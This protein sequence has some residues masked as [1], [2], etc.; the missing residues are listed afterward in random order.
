MTS[1]AER[2]A[3]AKLRE[4]DRTTEL[5][6]FTAGLDFQLD[7]FQVRACRALEAGDT[8][9]VAAPTGSGKTVVGEFAIHLAVTAGS[10]AFYTTPI[11][12]LSN[13]K[14]GDL[15]ATY[16]EAGVGL[17]TGDNSINGDAPVVVMTT[18]VLR[19]MLY[20]QSSALTGLSHVVMDEVHYLADRSRGAVWEEVLI[21]LPESV[22]VA[23]LSATVSNAEEFGDWL[24]TVRG[25]ATVIVE[26]HRPVP[27]WQHVAV[28]NRLHDLYADQDAGQLNPELARLAR[29]ARQAE[30]LNA[31]RGSYRRRGP[32]GP[33]PPSRIEVI[34]KL[35]Q[36]D[37]LPAITFIF[38]R[39][40]CDA[41]ADQCVAGGLRL[42]SAAEAALIRDIADTA[43]AH[44]PEA[45]L[46]LLGYDDWVDML[47]RGVAAHHAGMLPTFKEV[48]EGLF[49]QGLIKAVFATE[50]LALGINM[51]AR[52]VVLEKLSKWN[53]ETHADIT[54][55]EYTQL[56]GRAGRRGIDVEGHAVVVWHQ[57]LDPVDLAGRASTR[58]YPLR[59]S[60]HP[61]YNMAVNLV[62]QLGHHTAREVL[63]TSFAQFQADRAV[64]GLATQLRRQEEAAEGYREAMVC[65]LGDFVEYAGIRE[66]IGQREKSLSRAGQAA[67]RSSA[68]RTLER[69]RPGDIIVV[70]TGRRAGPA[71]VID[72]GLVDGEDP[73]PQ[74]MTVD[75][76]VR[77]LS[78]IDFPG[79]VEPVERLRI[80]KNFNAR[81]ATARRDL[82]HSL[83]DKV[84]GVEIRRPR[85]ERGGPGTADVE[86]QQLRARLRKHPCHGC[87]EREDHARWAQRYYRLQREIDSLAARV[88][89]RTNSIARQF[90]RVCAVLADL[91]YLTSAADGA[92]VTPPGGM[93]ARIYND[94]D[95]LAAEALRTGLWHGL[96]P[97]ELAAACSTLV[98]Q[99]RASEEPVAPRMPNSQV[100]TVIRDQGRLLA[101]LKSLEREHRVA[102]LGDLDA[103]FAWPAFRWVNGR[104][105]QEV[106]RECELAPGDFVRWCKQ[107]ADFLGQVAD[108]AGVLS[109]EDSAAVA[110]N[111]VLAARSIRRSVVAYSSVG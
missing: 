63:E 100:A 32:R 51:P 110:K 29:E 62:A 98:F 87:D 54:P 86:I 105:L 107:L 70:P 2:F 66:Q 93:L 25:S 82:A 81:S 10:R 19:N 31:N 55:G 44:L 109:G 11:K 89:Q 73:R 76:Q 85:K 92:E 104:P 58:T 59:S 101:D 41:A 33:R 38:S 30:K 67:R 111:A 96:D 40:G 95:L 79:P 106:L 60:F 99:G 15:V 74:V 22:S 34:E 42:T 43:C 3:A 12:A 39:A 14:F 52:S 17:L 1:P 50:T 53:G 49:Q 8:V 4:R 57:G 64:V 24:A 88:E 21:Q 36:D 94:N 80:P 84:R 71:V 18:E 77:R 46:A 103:R 108:A 23:A 61:S 7:D 9:L 90:D 47:S 13:Q 75:R 97:A 26:E 65:H 6:K 16:G 83:L 102:F 78:V 35:R 20:E 72:P 48:V 27:L 68:A 69:L 37:L 5:A 28:G 56:T 91:G 45:D